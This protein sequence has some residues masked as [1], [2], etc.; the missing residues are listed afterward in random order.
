MVTRMALCICRKLFAGRNN[1]FEGE[2]PKRRRIQA[3]RSDK[4]DGCH[5]QWTWLE[6]TLAKEGWDDGLET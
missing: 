3:F 5:R 1:Q 6:D 4:D 2:F